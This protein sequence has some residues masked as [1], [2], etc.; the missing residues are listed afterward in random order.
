[1]GQVVQGVLC[2]VTKG[3]NFNGF[4][5]GIQSLSM[6]VICNFKVRFLLLLSLSCLPHR[7]LRVTTDCQF[8]K[9]NAKSIHTYNVRT[10][11]C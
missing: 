1:M 4:I 11:G 8:K 5:L 9:G 6:Q 2:A 10:G 7:I 3:T